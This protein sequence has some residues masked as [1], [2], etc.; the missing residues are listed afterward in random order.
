LCPINNIYFRFI[1]KKWNKVSDEK[2]IQQISLKNHAAFKQ[3]VDR[4]QSLVFNTCYKLIGNQE[5][6][7][8]LAQEIFL[9]IYKSAKDFRYE[10]SFTTWIYRITINH[11]LN[12]L[13]NKKRF[14]WFSFLEDNPQNS[15]DFVMPDIEQPDIS[16][17]KKE[18]SRMIRKFINQL[19][20]K[21]KIAFVLHKFEGLP[22]KEIAEIM[23][24]S[25]SS[26]ESLI[27]RAKLKLQ[28]KL[29]IHFQES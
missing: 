3:L 23:Q 15:T 12:Y 2:L 9:N 28:E 29:I 25:L 14:L 11:S 6:V 19:P 24:K 20:D 4:Y 27:H 10:A 8:D 1:K 18:Q 16:F 22:Y 21:Q 17:E 5:D 26:V 13:R 7:E